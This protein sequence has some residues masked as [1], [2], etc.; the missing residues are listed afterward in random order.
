[1][2]FEVPQFIDMEA[3]IVGPLTLKQFAFIAV[4]A[5]LCFF[6]YFMVSLIVFIPITIILVSLG[7]SFA[8]IKINSR[9]LSLIVFLGI[10]Y[11]F[12][13][14]LFIWKRAVVEEVINL[15]SIQRP[16]ETTESRR[17]YLK[18]AVKSVS[19]VSKLFQDLTTTK[20]PIPKREKII[21]KKPISEIKEQFM[22][23]KK[24]S[25]D[26]EIAK[27]IDYR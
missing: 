1:M 18:E 12:S 2:Q 8:F 20:N 17:N 13:P 22:I 11:F 5:L 25:G 24:V 14:H 23:F 27:R 26:K 21:S 10:K 16:K 15:P 3:K 4:P 9:P 7:I 19:N 6:L